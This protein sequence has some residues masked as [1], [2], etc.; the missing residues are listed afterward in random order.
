MGIDEQEQRRRWDTM[1]GD[2]FTGNDDDDLPETSPT[3]RL[4][5]D[6]RPGMP[7]PPKRTIHN[8]DGDAADGDT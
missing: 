7:V 1:H 2:V 3:Y 5:H 8:S 6:W 4:G